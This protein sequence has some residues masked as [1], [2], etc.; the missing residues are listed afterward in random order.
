LKILVTGGS[1]FIGRRL[2]EALVRGGHDV[3]A[4]CREG[5]SGPPVGCAKVEW[6]EAQGMRFDACVH[7]AANNDTL[8]DDSWGMMRVNVFRPSKLFLSLARKGCHLFVHASTAAVYGNS[9]APYTEENLPGPLN[10]YA[11]SK[12]AFDEWS[13]DFAVETGSKV[14][15]LRYCNVYGPGESHKGRRA[16]MIFHIARSIAA[17]QRPRIFA[18]G[19]QVRDWVYVDDVVEANLACLSASKGGVFNIAGGAGASFNRIVEVVAREMGNEVTPE[20]VECP[21]EERFQTDTRCDISKAK[22]EL[23]W[24][25]KRDVESGI[26]EYLSLLGAAL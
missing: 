24:S 10:L 2:S 4:V 1:G 14:F 18:D 9:P 16:S 6:E 22:K 15:A 8:D 25:P 23:G 19:N 3:S 7:Q 13:S 17:G 26:R 5:E 11:R 12:L 21:F 20:Y